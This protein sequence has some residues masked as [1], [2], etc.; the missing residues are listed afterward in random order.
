LTA[1]RPG[2]FFRGSEL[3][4]LL[5]LAGVMVAGW[6]I[7]WARVRSAG[8]PPAPPPRVA[9]LTPLP[10]PDP[11]PP[12]QGLQDRTPMS[13]RDNAA[14]AELLRRAR[15]VPYAQLDA[16]SRRDVRFAQLIEDPARYRGLPLRVDG[17]V[18]RVLRQ[19]VAGSD[20]FPAGTYFEAYAI[21][22]DSQ[23]NPWVLAFETAPENLEVG[24]DLRQ[25]VQFDGYFLKLWAYKAGDTLR[26]A[27][28]LVGRFPPAPVPPASRPSSRRDRLSGNGAILLLLVALTAYTAL[29]F[30][31]QLRRIRARTPTTRRHRAPVRDQIEPDALQ[32]WIDATDPAP[33]DRPPDPD[34]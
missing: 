3:P 6:A 24:D 33:A 13:P 17:T 34:A 30:W 5:V 19:D 12:F 23:N 31:L 11:S 4:R 18:L 14:Y 20:L 8:P 22:P 10:P 2:P 27:P 25:R 15:T 32:G 21:T 28:L 16:D 7:L 26:V 9:D 29:R 1:A